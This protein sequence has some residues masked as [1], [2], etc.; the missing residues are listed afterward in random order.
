MDDLPERITKFFKSEG[1]Q[2]VIDA[3]KPCNRQ[4]TDMLLLTDPLLG[5][6]I[7]DR[8]IWVKVAGD[9]P[10]MRDFIPEG[11]N[12]YVCEWYNGK[13]WVMRYVC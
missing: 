10:K 6:F 8:V 7:M 11:Y 13:R 2:F 1:M 9:A 4:E 12:N 3:A 5:E